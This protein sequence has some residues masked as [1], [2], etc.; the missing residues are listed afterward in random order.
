M[1]IRLQSIKGFAHS[2][3][4]YSIMKKWPLYM[5]TKNT[6][7]KEYDG[8]FK[9]IFEDIFIRYS[10]LSLSLARRLKNV[11]F[12][13]LLHDFIFKLVYKACVLKISLSGSMTDA[14]R[15]P[16]RTSLSYTTITC[17][18][19]SLIFSATFENRKFC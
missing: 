3:F 14:S 18:A 13:F 9:D 11:N 12:I 1:L 6:I 5:S 8:R 7:L 17:F 15:T 19:I 10:I 4:Q 16:L 2:C